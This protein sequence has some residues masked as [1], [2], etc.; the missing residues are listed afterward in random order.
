[1]LRPLP[2][3]GCATRIW[4]SAEEP[5]RYDDALAYYE[6]A[7]ALDPKSPEAHARMGDVIASWANWRPWAGKTG[8]NA[9]LGLA[10]RGSLRSSP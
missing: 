9:A 8:G 10:G 6:R 1:V 5:A 4:E 7:I 2:A 3:L